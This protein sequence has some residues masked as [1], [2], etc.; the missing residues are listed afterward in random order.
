MKRHQLKGGKNTPKFTA[1][2]FR[3]IARIVHKV[4]ENLC[5][6]DFYRAPLAAY[7]EGIVVDGR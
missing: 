4:L 1:Q 7:L 3:H 5:K 2:S 6:H